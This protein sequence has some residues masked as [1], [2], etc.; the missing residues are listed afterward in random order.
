MKTILTD[1]L[2]NPPKNALSPK[3]CRIA[4]NAIAIFGGSFDP[5]HIGHIEVIKAALKNLKIDKLIIVPA[6]QNPFKNKTGADAKT[7]L[8]WL[9]EATAGIDS[10]EISS[11]EI[12]QNRPVPT[13]ETV[14]ALKGA[15]DKIYLIIG[16][17]NVAQLP[18]W[19]DYERL[20]S[21]VSFVVAT[22]SGSEISGDFLTLY[23]DVDISSTALRKN[24][25]QAFLPTK[26]TEEI[27]NYYKGNRQ[28]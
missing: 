27:T 6:F 16:A 18:Q 3:D 20:R 24:P 4:Y 26:L 5:V 19:H 22:R 8:R 11:Y 2:Y 14:Q 1:C 13:V 10:I 12:S 23:T 21:L 17:D 28:L 15:Y 9:K 25:D 7:R